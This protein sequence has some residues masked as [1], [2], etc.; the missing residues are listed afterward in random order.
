MPRST[1]IFPTRGYIL[2]ADTVVVGDVQAGTRGRAAESRDGSARLLN[3]NLNQNF[4]F[5]GVL[6]GQSGDAAGGYLLEVA[7]VPYGGAIGD[8]VGWVAAAILEADG[9]G[10][11]EAYIS[12]AEIHQAVKAAGSVEGDV[13]VAA[14]RATA[15]TGANGAAVPAGTLTLSLQPSE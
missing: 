14:V 3:T 4:T 13:R 8:A 10:I 15:G 5:K 12:G 1:G 11:T 7:H 2:D 6:Y 9:E